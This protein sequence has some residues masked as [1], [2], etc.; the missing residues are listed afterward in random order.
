[1]AYEL[2]DGQGSLFKNDKKGVEKRP[3]YRGDIKIDGTVYQLSAWLKE[4]KNGKF[5]SLNAQ[6][7]EDRPRR[8]EQESPQKQEDL[9]DDIPW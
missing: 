5:M 6:L 2:K 3:D 8:Q 7:K 9:N 1:M 4:G